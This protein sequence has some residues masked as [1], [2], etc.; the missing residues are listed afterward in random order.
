M[1]D[2]EGTAMVSKTRWRVL[3]VRA[4]ILAPTS[5]SCCDWSQSAR[6]ISRTVE[7]THVI[8]DVISTE[9]FHKFEVSR[10]CSGDDCQ[11]RSTYF[12]ISRNLEPHKD[13]GRI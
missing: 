3:F 9:T 7:E 6:R 1:E 2:D 5:G 13:P 4:L 10:R 11:T 12:T 8:K